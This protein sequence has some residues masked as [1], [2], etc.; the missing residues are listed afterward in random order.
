M[1]ESNLYEFNCLMTVSSKSLP[2][3]KTQSSGTTS[4]FPVE[5]LSIVTTLFPCSRRAQATNEPINPAAPVTNTFSFFYFLKLAP[6]L[7]LI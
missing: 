4:L 6:W 2:S 1:I 5:R 7:S 3:I